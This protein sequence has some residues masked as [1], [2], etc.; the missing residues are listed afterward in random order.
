ESAKHLRDSIQAT[1]RSQSDRYFQLEIES[2]I[3]PMEWSA[4]AAPGRELLARKKNR[5]VPPPA[6]SLFRRFDSQS[7]DVRNFPLRFASQS[8]GPRRL[9][10]AASR[11]CHADR[12]K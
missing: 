7:P 2:P 12:P 5:A 9:R 6:S 3:L 11:A 8:L 4:N 1:S 10:R